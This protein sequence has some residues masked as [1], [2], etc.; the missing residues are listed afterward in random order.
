MVPNSDLYLM[1]KVSDVVEFYKEP[2]RD[3]MAYDHLVR[4]QQRDELPP[5]LHVIPDAELY[6]PNSEFMG[7]IDAF[8]GNPEARIYGLR[9]KLK[10]PPVKTVIPWPDI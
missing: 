3:V 4:V 8:P 2:V 5:N 6:D 10:Y 9:D 7:G 1:K